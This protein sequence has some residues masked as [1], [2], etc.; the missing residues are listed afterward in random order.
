VWGALAL[1]G[2]ALG[3]R[4]NRV[5]LRAHAAVYAAAAAWSSGMLTHALVAFVGETE[6]AATPPSPVELA[7]LV[8]VLAGWWALVATRRYRSAPRLARMPRFAILLVALAG[9]AT[10]LVAAVAAML[11]RSPDPPDPG[12][13]ALVR[14]VALSIAAVVLAWGRRR[15]GLPE[16]AW[17][18]YPVLAAIALKI[19]LQDVRLGEPATLFPGFAVYGLALI[20]VPR[21]LGTGRRAEPAD[22]PGAA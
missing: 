17:P 6:R 18:V 8:L 22:G 9:L 16:L 19:L 12:A 1:V 11:A 3:G 2:A 13:V 7:I 4:W 15:S 21:L 20:L 14:T 10:V 5:T